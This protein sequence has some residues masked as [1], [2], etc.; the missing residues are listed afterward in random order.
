MYMSSVHDGTILSWGITMD[1]RQTESQVVLMQDFDIPPPVKCNTP[2]KL[3]KQCL[4][5]S[6]INVNTIV[7]SLKLVL[8]RMTKYSSGL[9]KFCVYLQ[10]WV[11]MISRYRNQ[12]A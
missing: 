10:G 6:L 5:H 9:V 3:S 12:Q 1:A 11:K 2:M 7:S 8:P 4:P